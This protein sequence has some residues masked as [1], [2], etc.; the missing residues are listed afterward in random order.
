M[1]FKVLLNESVISQSVGTDCKNNLHKVNRE[2][3]GHTE[4]GSQ[5]AGTQ[6]TGNH[7]QSCD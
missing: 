7:T 1:C 5:F 3:E 2:G 6:G 4:K